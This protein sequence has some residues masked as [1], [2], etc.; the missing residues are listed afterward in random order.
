M[1]RAALLSAVVAASGL[2][3]AA[4]AQPLP[5]GGATAQEIAD[6]LRREGLD[7]EVRSEGDDVWVAS[8]ANGLSWDLNAYDCQAGRC[9]SW[10]FS[11]GFVM[12]RLPDGVLNDWHLRHRYIKAFSVAQGD[13]V[14]VLAQYDVLLAPGTTWEGMSEHLYLFAGTLPEFAAHIGFTPL[15]PDAAAG[16]D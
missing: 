7:A 13:G 12:D 2:A 11:A 9:A 8:G 10:Q 16:D 6:W 4:I 15:G 14:A 1:I 5:E 3:P